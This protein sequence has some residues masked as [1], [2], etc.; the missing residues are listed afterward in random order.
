VQSAI[1]GRRDWRGRRDENIDRLKELPDVLAC[2]VEFPLAG[3]GMVA[4]DVLPRLD[5]AQCSGDRE[6]GL[7]TDWA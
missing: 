1:V 4:T 3:A 7:A 6:W 2:D 5:A